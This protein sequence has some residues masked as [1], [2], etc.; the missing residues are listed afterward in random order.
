MARSSYIYLA[1]C[2]NNWAVGLFWSKDELVAWLRLRQRKAS[3][4]IR[5]MDSNLRNYINR[6]GANI[7]DDPEIQPHL[8]SK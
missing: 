5:L 3:S 1:L 2:P 6:R 8:R 4:V 7:S